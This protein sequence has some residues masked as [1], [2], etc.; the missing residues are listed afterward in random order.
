MRR[1]MQL[2]QCLAHNKCSGQT[3]C[4]ECHWLII[5]IV[6]ISPHPGGNQNKVK[7][8]PCLLR[9]LY[10]EVVFIISNNHFL[11]FQ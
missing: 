6:I 2:P 9:L 8:H 10:V 11:S 1:C 3:N 4:Y 7:R 5:V